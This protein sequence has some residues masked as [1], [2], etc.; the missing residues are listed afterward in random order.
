MER[1]RLQS[2]NFVHNSSG[3]KAKVEVELKMRLMFC[4]LHSVSFGKSATEIEFS[5]TV[6]T[7]EYF[8]VFKPHILKEK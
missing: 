7:I 2:I 4:V 3:F 6:L 1:N 5:K 8:S